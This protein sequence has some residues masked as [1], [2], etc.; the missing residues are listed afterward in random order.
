[1]LSLLQALLGCGVP[2]L[3][4][5]VVLLFIMRLDTLPGL[6][7]NLSVREAPISPPSLRAAREA[8]CRAGCDHTVFRTIIL[9]S[10]VAARA[11]RRALFSGCPARCS[12]AL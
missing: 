10:C 2:A 3:A 11:R 9:M 4:A 1:M 5:L 7:L 12:C 8:R 6:E